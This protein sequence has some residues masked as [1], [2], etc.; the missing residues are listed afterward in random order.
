MNISMAIGRFWRSG[1]SDQKKNG[2]MSRLSAAI[3]LAFSTCLSAPASAAVIMAFGADSGGF[4]TIELSGSVDVGAVS[5]AYGGTLPISST[6]AAISQDGNG[7]IALMG[8]GNSA[9][10]VLLPLASGN[11]FPFFAPAPVGL[12]TAHTGQDGGLFGAS[13]FG[14]DGG[15][16]FTTGAQSISGFATYNILFASIGFGPGFFGAYE[17]LGGETVTLID[18]TTSVTPVP[19]PAG[20]LLILTGLGAICIR[21]R[22][23]T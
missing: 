5:T 9:E 18:A 8:S 15:F 23:R 19:L 1:R 7:P 12:Q 16:R 20:G 6:S 11:A 17:L 3:A 13:A 4:L 22:R 10:I 14:V 21:S 2:V